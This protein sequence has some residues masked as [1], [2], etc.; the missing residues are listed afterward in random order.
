MCTIETSKDV[1]SHWLEARLSDVS[2]CLERGKSKHRPRNAAHLYGG[3]YPFVQTGDIARSNGII[4]QHHQTYSESGL[5]QSRLWPA[6]T[7]CITIAANIGSSAIL[8]YPACF[9]DSIVGILVN[10]D[11]CIPKYLEY[12]IRTIRIELERLAPAT[13]QKNINVAILDEVLI[14]LAPLGE[15]KRIVDKLDVLLERVDACR[16]RLTRI[17]RLLQRLRKSIIQKATSGALSALW[18]TQHKQIAGDWF[19]QILESVENGDI[20]A[21]RK[22]RLWGSGQTVEDSSLSELPSNWKW[23]KIKELGLIENAVQIG[24]MSMKSSEFSES[25]TPVLNVGCVN[26]NSINL[27]KC[28]FLPEKKAQSFDRY[29][30]KSGDIIFTRSGTVGRA[31]I[32]PAELD[33]CLMTFHLL[34][35]RTSDRVCLPKYLLYAIEGCSEVL[36]QIESTAIGATRAGFNTTLLEGL[37]IPLPPPEEQHFIV[38]VLDRVLARQDA[39]SERLKGLQ[40]VLSDLTPALL[41]QAFRGELVPQ[42]A[43]D[44]PAPE[45]LARIGKGA[46]VGPAIKEKNGKR[47]KALVS[48]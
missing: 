6:G 8:S 31:A 35:I 26:W 46:Q 22:V 24:P 36:S 37:S 41:A 29:R 7:I 45:L 34:R 40:G 21:A 38:S 15:Q 11:L 20:K 25:G 17:A 10:Q 42:N 19:Q 27:R 44:G 47:S 4:H 3:P 1:P 12:F 13:A 28:N 30:L 32:L 16:E 23:V 43:G 18:R 9:P 39:Q 14:P 2:L 33:G 5:K 48:R